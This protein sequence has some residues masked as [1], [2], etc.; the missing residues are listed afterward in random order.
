MTHKVH[1]C[2]VGDGKE[3]HQQRKRTACLDVDYWRADGLECYQLEAGD[4]Q[5]SR[6]LALE[7]L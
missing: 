2:R 3:C 4:C 7:S 1:C 5:T 6:T